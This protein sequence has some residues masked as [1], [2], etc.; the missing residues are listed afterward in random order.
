MK[1]N[2]MKASLVAMTALALPAALGAKEQSGDN[3]VI[4]GTGKTATVTIDTWSLNGKEVSVKAPNGFTVSPTKLKAN[5]KTKINV[6]L[7]SSRDTT[8]GEMILRCG[9]I[10]KYIPLTGIGTPLPVKALGNKS[11]AKGKTAK[12]EQTFK[13]GSNGYTIEF[14]LKS[15]EDDQEFHPWFVDANG[16]GFQANIAFNK[17]ALQNSYEKGIDNPATKG[18]EGGGKFYNNDRLSHTYRIAVT[19]D[20]L[21]FI[22][23]DG[24]LLKTARINDYAPRP[25]FATGKG[26]HSDNLLKNGDFEGEYELSAD[27]ERVDAVEGWDIVVGDRWN[28]EQKV[29]KLGL[30]NTL[31]IDNHVFWIRPYKWR[32]GW[33][34]GILEQVVDVVPGETYTLTALAK[35][36]VSKKQSKNLGKLTISEV[37]DRSLSTSTT[38]NS[39]EWEQ[40]EL[41]YKPSANCHQLAIQ[42]SDGRGGWGNDITW[43]WAD[44]VK[45]SGVGRTYSPKVG[46]NNKG[47]EVEYFTIDESGAYAPETPNINVIF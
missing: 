4:K 42:I 38:I 21:A 11:L 1:N 22:Y 34:D 5:G 31:D 19:A 30:D 40:Y 18:C 47:S 45:L 10:R 36:G 15:M 16:H 25:F 14:R 2:L 27:K 20:G 33:S 7:T 46:F 29:Q 3:L 41:S 23:R 8:R 32:A 39:D 43:V 44:N 17:V 24:V 28:S 35:G 9:D 26:K 37:Q 12:L 6:T 13:P